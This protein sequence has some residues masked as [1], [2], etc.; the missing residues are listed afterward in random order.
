MK[1]DGIFHPINVTSLEILQIRHLVFPSEIEGYQLEHHVSQT[2]ET[3]FK[4]T[5][6]KQSGLKWRQNTKGDAH[7]EG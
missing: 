5:G 1:V 7:S 6:L 4:K 2:Y 3:T